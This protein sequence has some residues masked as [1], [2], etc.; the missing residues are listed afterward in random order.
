MGV[1]GC[2]RWPGGA[3]VGA[4]RKKITDLYK[5]HRAV[6]DGGRLDEV[7][8]R[9]YRQIRV[10]KENLFSGLN[11]LDVYTLLARQLSTCFGFTEAEVG[12]LAERHGRGDRMEEIRRRGFQPC[13]RGERRDVGLS[14]ARQSGC[15]TVYRLPRGDVAHSGR[16][17]CAVFCG[18]EEA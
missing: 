11:N 16:G 1:G 2:D 8:Q 13:R 3:G 7:A 14:R 18:R 9:R 17:A 15:K 12:A 6:L 5:A 10:A 4:I